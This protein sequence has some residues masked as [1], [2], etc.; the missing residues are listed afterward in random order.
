MTDV[1]TFNDLALEQE[2]PCIP[3]CWE[4][5]QMV[6]DPY[7]NACKGSGTYPTDYGN[8]VLAFIQK[9]L[10]VKERT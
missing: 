4:N 1:P 5:K 8:K 2:C 10:D 3:K 7:C 6:P 9:Y